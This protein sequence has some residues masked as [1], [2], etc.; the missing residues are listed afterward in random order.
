M[1]IFIAYKV[2]VS[3]LPV[4]FEMSIDIGIGNTL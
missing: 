3:V 1:C 4:L 2:L